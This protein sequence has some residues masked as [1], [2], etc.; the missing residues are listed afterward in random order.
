[1]IDLCTLTSSERKS[2]EKSLLDLSCEGLRTLCISQRKLSEGEAL[3]WLE[4]F[5]TAS[6]SFQNRSDQLAVVGCAIEVDME[7]L[8]ITAIEDRLQD[9]VPEVIAD[10]ARAGMSHPRNKTNS[11]TSSPL[12]TTL[13]RLTFSSPPTINTRSPPLP[14]LAT[15]SPSGIVLWMLTGDKEETAVNIGHSCNL[16]LND[17]YVHFLTKLT[18]PDMYAERLDQIYQEVLMKYDPTKG[19][20]HKDGLYTT[21]AMVMDGPSFEHFQVTNKEQ[22]KQLLKIGQ[23]CRSVIAC[24]L[25]PIQKQLVTPP[26][27]YY[28]ALAIL[29]P[30]DSKLTH[31]FNTNTPSLAPFFPPFSLSC[32]LCLFPL[33]LAFAFCLLS[34]ADCRLGGEHC[35]DRQC[36]PGDVFVH[37][38]WCQRRFHDPRSRR[39]RG[40]LRKGR[41]TSGKQR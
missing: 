22:R 3:A 28:H 37:R 39:G 36:A 38:R 13:S 21:M 27:Q 11:N 24:R 1:M 8:G 19:Y 40:H 29:T 41:T 18:S 7:L 34:L 17:T 12:N 23:S 20:R 35:Q 10:L 25:T 31:P 5:K 30:L 26:S 6:T 15:P 2:I 14:P 9:E 16:L 33:P 4:T 32:F